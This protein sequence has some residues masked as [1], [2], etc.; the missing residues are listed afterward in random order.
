MELM[1]EFLRSVFLNLYLCQSETKNLD[2]FLRGPSTNDL[3]SHPI[4]SND[5]LPHFSH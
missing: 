5:N 1:R 2:Q 4:L 3:P